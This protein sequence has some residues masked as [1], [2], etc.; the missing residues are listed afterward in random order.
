VKRSML[1]INLKL[2]LFMKSTFKEFK[3]DTTLGKKIQIKNNLMGY[4]R[5]ERKLIISFK[6]MVDRLY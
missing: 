2:S 6:L 5:V 1:R 3:K 4:K